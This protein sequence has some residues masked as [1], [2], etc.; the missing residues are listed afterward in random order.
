MAC[1]ASIIPK[2]PGIF[3]RIFTQKRRQILQIV[4]LY[5]F[6]SMK[7][8]WFRS[9]SH[10]YWPADIGSAVSKI[11][12]DFHAWLVSISDF[13]RWWAAITSPM[14][15]MKNNK[16]VRTKPRELPWKIIYDATATSRLALPSMPL[17]DNT[18]RGFMTASCVPAS[19]SFA[20]LKTMAGR[21]HNGH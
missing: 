19:E 20:R 10:Q 1:I 17:H 7:I 16:S 8:K 15:E 11:K 14:S 12:H 21:N 3:D 5:R 4:G 9:E 2:M 18:R 13:H 6:S